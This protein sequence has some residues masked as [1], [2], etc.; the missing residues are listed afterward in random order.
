MCGGGGGT[1]TAR[2]IIDREKQVLIY[3][4]TMYETEAGWGGTDSKT[5]YRHREIGIIQSQTWGGGGGGTQTARLSD[6]QRDRNN[7]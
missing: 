3:S 4:D 1:Q 7:R 6:C 2:Q 5:D